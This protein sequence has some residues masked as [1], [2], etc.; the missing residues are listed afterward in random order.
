MV[1]AAA[2]SLYRRAIDT[3][4]IIEGAWWDVGPVCTGPETIA[5]ERRSVT[6]PSSPYRVAVPTTVSQLVVTSQLYSHR[7]LQS[8]HFRKLLP[9]HYDSANPF[10][11]SWY[12][13]CSFTLLFH[14]V[15]YPNAE[16][17]EVAEAS[18]LYHRTGTRWV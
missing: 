3:V 2:R 1:N 15:C 5:H 12:Q 10:H 14:N 4:P 9:V 7:T 17:A 18:F 11:A 8:V 13:M 16:V 6:G